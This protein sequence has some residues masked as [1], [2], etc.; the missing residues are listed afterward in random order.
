MNTDLPTTPGLAD[1]LDPAH[2]T[3][4]ERDVVAQIAKDGTQ[5]I[6]FWAPW[7]GNAINELTSGFAEVVKRQPGAAFTFVTIWNEGASGAET[8]THFGLA[9]RVHEVLADG[10]GPR[11]PRELRRRVFLGLPL[12]WIPT[13]WIFHKNGELAF[14]FNYGEL[15]PATLEEALAA[16]SP[17]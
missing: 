17:E 11:E 1:R 14:A 10:F 4:A 6:H 3:P 9:E 7:C 8:L 16:T 12:T 5:V 13:T 15:A 2:L